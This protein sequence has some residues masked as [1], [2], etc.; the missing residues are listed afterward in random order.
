MSAGPETAERNGAGLP[1]GSTA[2]SRWVL[3][4]LCVALVL[5]TAALAV[6]SGTSLRYLDERH[7][8]QLAL[9]L[10]SGDGFTTASGLPTAFR[11]PGYPLFLAA[12]YQAWSSPLAAKLANAVLLGLLAWILGGMVARHAPK[13]QFLPPILILLYPV[14]PY[15][16][17][18]LYPQTLGAVLL[19]GCVSLLTQPGHPWRPALLA[20]LL[21]GG[22]CLTIPS[23][24]LLVP[25]LAVYRAAT[26][27]RKPSRALGLALILLAVPLATLSPWTLRNALRFGE[28]IP[29]STNS[30][31]NLYLGNSPN[32]GPTD[33]VNVEI[34]EADRPDPSWSEA[35]TDRHYRD[36]AWKWIRHH[37]GKAARL[38]LRKV[39]GY[40]HFRNKLFTTDES[41]RTRDV[42]M[43]ITYY[44]L[45]LAGF[46]RIGLWKR[47]PLANEERLCALLYLGNA[48]C[49]ALFFP[50][51]RFRLPF[52]ALLIACAASLA[53]RWMASRLSAAS[54]GRR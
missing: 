54:P 48:F 12:L 29:V 17:T 40:F 25:L 52:D 1:Q 35:R 14:L 9:R 45:L 53:G 10:C 5:L 30:G 2:P 24:L 36:L 38:Y 6:R 23:F 44:P 49:A 47:F 3:G 15:T 4:L 37:P 18:T 28:F 50:R 33:G 42:V 39:G 8:H 19:A 46:L 22:V 32:A 43:A 16:A 11:P 27:W 20:G 51:I 34:P 7:Y 41:S 26:H 13:G 31:R 21:L